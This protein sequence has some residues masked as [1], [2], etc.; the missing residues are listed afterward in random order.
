[1]ARRRKCLVPRCKEHARY[2]GLCIGHYHAAWRRVRDGEATWDGLQD[3]NLALPDA[4]K[5]T[6]DSAIDAALAKK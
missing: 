4:R 2:R 1:M 3:L 5:S 6:L